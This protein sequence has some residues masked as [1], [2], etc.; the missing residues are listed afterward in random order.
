MR[1]DHLA[2]YPTNPS[3]FLTIDALEEEK[4]DIPPIL[5]QA[6]RDTY[7]LPGSDDI[8]EQTEDVS[9]KRERAASA[10]GKERP[11]KAMRRV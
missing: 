3:S 4:M 9:T 7:N 10:V 1:K 2:V 6:Y 11:A 5:T 8:E